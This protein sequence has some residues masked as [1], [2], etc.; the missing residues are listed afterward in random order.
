MRLDLGV[1]GLSRL[2]VYE[3]DQRKEVWCASS[4]CAQTF[5]GATPVLTLRR[6]NW[7]PVYWKKLSKIVG[8][9]LTCVRQQERTKAAE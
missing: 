1:T 9:E 6:Y 7:S 5:A 8:Q 4:L 3:G 2:W